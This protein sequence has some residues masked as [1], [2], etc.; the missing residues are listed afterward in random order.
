MQ[1][2][3]THKDSNLCSIHDPSICIF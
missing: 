3:G 1:T 2:S